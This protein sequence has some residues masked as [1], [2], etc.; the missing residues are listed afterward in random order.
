M[1]KV[2][3]MNKKQLIISGTTITLLIAAIVTAFWY[4]SVRNKA[5]TSIENPVPPAERAQ[6]LEHEANEVLYSDPDKAAKD[7]QEAK[8]L[9]EEAG[10]NAKAS[11]AERNASTAEAIR[12][13][14]KSRESNPQKGVLAPAVVEPA[15][16]AQ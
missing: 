16:S 3:R 4:S 15:E 7:L 1:V 14:N 10:D 8:R 11:E 13:F 6:S 5:H 12:N 2:K 9:Y